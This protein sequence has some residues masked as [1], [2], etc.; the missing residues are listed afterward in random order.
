M[1]LPRVTFHGVTPR[2][3]LPRFIDSCDLFLITS[4]TEGQCLV[5]LEILSR[6]R[7]LVATPV[8][9][10]P[11]VLRAT[12]LG[13]LAPLNDAAVYAGAVAELADQIGKGSITPETIV[14][15]F[16]E[17]FDY[18]AILNRYIDMLAGLGLPPRRAAAA[19][20]AS[21]TS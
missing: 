5:A 10:L 13:R 12:E 16:R 9:A 14:A 17:R 11:D 2:A 21:L 15:S 8:G 7:P 3:E 19:E 18:E 4:L 6:G 1:A 20:T